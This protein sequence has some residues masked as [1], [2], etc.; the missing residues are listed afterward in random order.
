MKREVF[1]NRYNPITIEFQR[2][3]FPFSLIGNK[4]RYLVILERNHK[5]TKNTFDSHVSSLYMFVEK[6]LTKKLNFTLSLYFNDITYTMEIQ[7]FK[8][9]CVSITNASRGHN[10]STYEKRHRPNT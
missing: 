10:L 8:G 4:P 6:N 3:S 1:P 5:N 9:S 2:K 7:R